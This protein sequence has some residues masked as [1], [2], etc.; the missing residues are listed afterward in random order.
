MLFRSAHAHKLAHSK[1]KIPSWWHTP[2]IT[3]DRE[4]RQG[5]YQCQ[6]HGEFQTSKDYI[7]RPCLNVPLQHPP[8]ERG[9]DEV[10]RQQGAKATWFTEVGPSGRT[11]CWVRQLGLPVS[12]R[13]LDESEEGESQAGEGGGKDRVERIVWSQ[14]NLDWSSWIVPLL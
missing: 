5:H 4:Q 8:T 13:S 9:H 10:S 7:V 11:N 1:K 14:T 6:S 3:A 12:G 2:V